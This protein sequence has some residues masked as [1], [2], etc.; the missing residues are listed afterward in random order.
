MSLSTQG[1]T[2]YLVVDEVQ[3]LYKDRTS[4][5]RRKSTVFWE[6]VKLVRNDAAS[7][8]RILMFG[9]YG[10]DPQYTQSMTPVD[11]SADMV[12]GIK[13]LNFRREEIEEYVE[14]WF[15]GIRCLQGTMKTFCDCLQFLTGGHVGLCAV[16][17]GVL[18]TVYFSRVGCGGVTPFA[19]DWICMLEQGSLYREKDHAL[20][21]ALI[22][23]CAV[24]V[25]TTLEME[26]LDG[27]ERLFYGV[28]NHL[29]AQLLDE[30]IRKGIL[31]G[32]EGR[33]EFSS[34]VMWRYFVKMRVGHVDRALHGPNT[35]QE[36]IARVVR[37]IDYDSIRKTLGRTLSNDIPLE[38]AWQMEFYKASYRCT[39]STCVTSADVGALFGSTGFI[40]FTVEC[41]D[42]FWGI[43]LLREGSAL[44]EHIGRFAPGGSYSLLQLSD[45]CLVDFRRVSSMEDT[46]RATTI[47]DLNRCEKLYVVCYDRKLAHVSV[48]N[49][50]SVWNI[51]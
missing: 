2:I 14:K 37:A 3:I 46:A 5:P 22:L 44:D 23:T 15:V 1:Y 24:K 16:A 27:L 47:Q 34:P 36:M 50:Q 21:D 18:N 42:N 51:S 8:I 35:L 33:V 4:S 38:R 26:D 25:L 40:D 43:E 9:A 7:T 30:C 12:L 10:S 13:H 48:L 31:I 39:P 20:F 49:S 32:C 41:G 19:Y 6:L 11:F 29:D 17:I 28:E 45:Y